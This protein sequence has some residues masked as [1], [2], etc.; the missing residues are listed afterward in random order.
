MKTT[1]IKGKPGIRIKENG[2]FIAT[3]SLHGIRDTKEFTTLREAWAW[4]QDRS[5][6]DLTVNGKDPTLSGQGDSRNEILFRDVYLQYVAEGMVSLKPQSIKK[7]TRRMVRFLPSLFPIPMSQMDSRAVL[8]HVIK[9]VA[10]VDREKSRRCNFEKELKDLSSIFNW[11]N[12]EVVP[13][14]N[15]IRQ[16]HFDAGDFRPVPKPKKDLPPNLVPHVVSNMKHMHRLVL[17]TQFLLGARIGEACGINDKTVDFRSKSIDLTETIIWDDSRPVHQYDNKTST[18]H[19]KEMTPMIEAILREAKSLRPKGCIYFFQKKGR[20]LRYNSILEDLNET[21]DRLNLGEYSGTHIFRYSM[22]DFT[23]E[24]EGR[25]VAQAM[26]N[27]VDSRQTEHYAQLKA[28][29]KVAGVVIK[30]ENL[31]RKFNSGVQPACNQ[32]EETAI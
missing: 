26:L 20:P 4:K 19:F 23:R 15:P 6:I 28:N 5:C 16:K 24:E 9:M 25:E 14:V 7:K 21:L 32:G 8:Q 3:K 27:H 2:K 30:A 10:V 13:F 12:E 31:F 29:K 11:Y 22:A 17:T 18:I 1:A